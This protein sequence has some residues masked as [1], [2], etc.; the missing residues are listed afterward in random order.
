[1]SETPRAHCLAN[2][3]TIFMRRG[4]AA[5]IAVFVVTLG[6]AAT[7]PALAAFD[8]VC[9]KHLADTNP[10][11]HDPQIAARV[12]D[13]A[14]ELL[15]GDPNFMRDWNA[16]TVEV[17][18]GD[19]N[20]A[21]SAPDI[22]NGD[23]RAADAAID[24][25]C[26]APL[27]A[28]LARV[29]ENTIRLDVDDWRSYVNASVVLLGSGKWTNQQAQDELNKVRAEDRAIAAADFTRDCL[30]M[31]IRFEARINAAGSIEVVAKQ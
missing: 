27:E 22:P 31:Q 29:D 8:A 3:W 19:P 13:L 1:M 25:H 9:T 6:T 10:T 17:R 12:K 2:T 7:R 23:N 5:L 21:P 14:I 18:K 11:T 24:L 15:A 26:L 30:L 28:R 16:Y 20:A 4:K